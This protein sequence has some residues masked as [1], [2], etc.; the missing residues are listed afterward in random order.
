MTE[1]CMPAEVKDYDVVILGEVVAKPFPRI[2]LVKVERYYKGEGAAYLLVDERS[3]HFARSSWERAPKGQPWVTGYQDG[4]AGLG[5]VWC[6]YSAP[7]GDASIQSLEPGIPPRWGIDL[8]LRLFWIDVALMLV[9]AWVAWVI[10]RAYWPWR[11]RGP[12]AEE[13]VV[14]DSSYEP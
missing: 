14:S 5:E 4:P 8:G 7:P 6:G 9:A 12:D 2:Y 11:R 1:P 13:E 10:I 3:G